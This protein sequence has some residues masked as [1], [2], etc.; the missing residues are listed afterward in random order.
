MFQCVLRVWRILCSN[1]S[2]M[3]V[4]CRICAEDRDRTDGVRVSRCRPVRECVFILVCV[5]FTLQQDAVWTH[6]N[7][8]A[9]THTHTPS[10]RHWWRADT[11]YLYMVII[12][13]KE[14]TADS[15]EK[16]YKERRHLCHSF[17]KGIEPHINFKYILKRAKT[18]SSEVHIW[19]W[20]ALSTNIVFLIGCFSYLS[21][22]IGV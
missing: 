20:L 9:N 1:R 10:P 22:L 8:H 7:A 14:K 5:Y 21:F 17:H 16:D 3:L 13:Y 6:T 18:K 2:S 12:E 11:L 19:I 15:D 4:C